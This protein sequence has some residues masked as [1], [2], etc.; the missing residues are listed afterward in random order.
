MEQLWNGAPDDRRDSS[1]P[2]QPRQRR[3][4]V[5]AFA[6]RGTASLTLY[7]LS[8]VATA[9]VFLGIDAIWLSAMGGL[10]YRPI[11]GDLLLERFKLAPAIAFYAAYVAGIVIFAVAPAIASGRWTTAL[12]QGALFGFCAYAT[13]N[14]TNL[15]ILKNWSTLVTL[16]DLCWGTVL[17]GVSASAGYLLARAALRALAAH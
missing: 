6:R 1:D 12:L 2:R 3:R 8:Y 7:I 14:L 13:Y 4:W 5:R 15:A 11:L 17:T 10:L 16:V 9:C